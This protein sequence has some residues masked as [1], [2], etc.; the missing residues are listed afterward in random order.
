MPGGKRGLAMDVSGLVIAVVVLTA[1]MQDNTT[2]I[3]LLD[4]VV[5]HGAGLGIDVEIVER[6]PA[7]SESH[8]IRKAV[9]RIGP[10]YPLNGII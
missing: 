2:G 8:P 10:Q 1:N 6:S 3:V 5:A 9:Y 7:I 4:Q